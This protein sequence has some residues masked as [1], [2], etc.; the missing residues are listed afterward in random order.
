MTSS[1]AT[2][3]HT[4]T[5]ATNRTDARVILMRIWLQLGLTAMVVV[6]VIAG[7]ATSPGPAAPT[8]AV[9]GS[10]TQ[11]RAMNP[12]PLD[13]DTYLS[14]DDSFYSFLRLPGAV[15]VRPPAT[16]EAGAKSATAVVLATVEDVRKTRDIPADGQY[17]AAI[18]V[19]VVL[20]ITEVLKGKLVPTAPN[21]VVEFVMT[22]ES[23]LELWRSTLPKGQAVW[24][25]EWLGEN[26]L[27]PG[28]STSE[29][30][31]RLY[32]LIS[33]QGVLT[34]GKTSVVSILEESADS[35]PTGTMA[36]DALRYTT[37]SEATSAVKKSP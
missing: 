17:D 18:K 12:A 6:P 11:V 5:R 7:C 33:M 10:P 36:Q 34:Q 27:E 9:A 30:D 20:K 13:L 32:G 3:S 26:R 31:K 4:S 21:P 35:P 15:M 19:G 23:D 22:D 24:F 28:K 37:L 16:L 2:T 29:V 8:A 25:L 14:T 1:T